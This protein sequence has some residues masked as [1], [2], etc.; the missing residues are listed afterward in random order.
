[1]RELM[2]GD[3]GTVTMKNNNDEVVVKLYIM[4]DGSLHEDSWICPKGWK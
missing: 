1:M 4:P 2:M 3:L